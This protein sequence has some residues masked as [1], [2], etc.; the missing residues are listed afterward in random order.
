[1][2]K[3]P[4]LEGHVVEASGAFR[5]VEAKPIGNHARVV[6]SVSIRINAG[7]QPDRIALDILSGGRIEVS[8]VVLVQNRRPLE[9]LTGKP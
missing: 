2:K 6:F 9:D 1:M 8:E 7:A 5:G 4:H 3:R